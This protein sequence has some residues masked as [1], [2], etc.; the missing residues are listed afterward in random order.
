[1]VHPLPVLRIEILTLL[2][3]VCPLVKF[4]FWATLTSIK[5]S[6]PSSHKRVHSNAFVRLLQTQKGLTR[7]LSRDKFARLFT[8]PLPPIEMCFPQ[9][10][11]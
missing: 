10:R 8:L 4:E 5:I 2:I 9:D 11:T 3:P 6:S 1:M 7:T